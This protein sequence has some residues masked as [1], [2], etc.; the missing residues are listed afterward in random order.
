MKNSTKIR[1]AA[2]VGSV[3]NERKVQSIFDISTKCY[4]STSAAFENGK[5]Q[6][7]D[8]VTSSEFSGEIQGDNIYFFDNETSSHVHL[9]L[10]NRKFR[11]YDYLTGCS[12]SGSVSGGFIS[13][14]DEFSSHYSH[15]R[16]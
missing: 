6:G 7:Y 4:R 13:L 5:L 3:A 10:E 15:F 2:A 9:R 11:G 12:F 8:F 1:I 16:V 14:R